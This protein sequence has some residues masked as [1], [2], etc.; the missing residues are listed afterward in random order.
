[1]IADELRLAGLKVVESRPRGRATGVESIEFVYVGDD[2][3]QPISD[4]V[5]AALAADASYFLDREMRVWILADGALGSSTVVK[6]HVAGEEGDR[7]SRTDAVRALDAVLSGAYDISAPTPQKRKRAAKN[8][9]S[10]TAP[11]DTE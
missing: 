8:E 4:Q 1:M 6:V 7:E 11:E 10:E 9:E 2:A 3:E 5:N